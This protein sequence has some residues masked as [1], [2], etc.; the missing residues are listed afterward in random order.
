M[1]YF[2]KPYELPDNKLIKLSDVLKKKIEKKLIKGTLFNGLW[3][4][5]GTPERLMGQDNL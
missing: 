3:I 5:I 4:D 1:Q 2:E